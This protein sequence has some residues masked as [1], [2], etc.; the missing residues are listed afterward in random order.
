MNSPT[1]TL[2]AR[3]PFLLFCIPQIRIPHETMTRVLLVLVH[4][5]TANTNTTQ[6]ANVFHFG[7]T[8]VLLPYNC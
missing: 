1:R 8:M 6:E 3:L 7:F 2:D 5:S 4:E